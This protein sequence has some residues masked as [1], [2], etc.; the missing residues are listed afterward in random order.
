[1]KNTGYVRQLDNEGRI[2]IPT[3]I[4]KSLEMENGKDK[5]EIYTEGTLVVL[6]KY[7]PSCIFCGKLDENI[8]YNGFSVCKECIE[9]LSDKAKTV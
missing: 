5:F 1:M 4:R 9:K 7:H 2:V 8:E 6:K 3:S